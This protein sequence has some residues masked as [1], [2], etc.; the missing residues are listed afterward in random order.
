MHGIRVGKF[1]V[2]RAE[3]T[4]YAGI[5][6]HTHPHRKREHEVLQRINKR[7]GVERA[8]VDTGN[9]NAVH[10]IIHRLNKHRNHGRHS[11]FHKQTENRLF[12]Q[13]FVCAA[14]IFVFHKTP[15]SA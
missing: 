10:D 6:P 5:K 3:R 11:H 8:V 2:F 15:R 13:Q 9:E 12:A 14:E 1:A 4:G 7:N